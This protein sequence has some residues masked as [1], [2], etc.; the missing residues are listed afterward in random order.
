MC[1]TARVPVLV[2][3]T[4]V[5]EF[6]PVCPN[7]ATFTVPETAAFGSVVGRVAGTDSDYPLDS[8]EYSLEG[9][10]GSAQPFSIDRRTGEHP[11]P[12]S[13]PATARG[14]YSFP[15]ARAFPQARST[16]W[17]PWT[18]SSRTITGWWCG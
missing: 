10:S 11:V 12:S 4:P 9:D 13:A 1:H 5:N 14:I 8:L 2:T 15:A 3:V 16:W 18:L 7:G 17:D 6:R